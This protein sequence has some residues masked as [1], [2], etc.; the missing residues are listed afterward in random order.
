MPMDRQATRFFERRDEGQERRDRRRCACK[1][2]G[3]CPR[4]VMP[5][6]DK[7]DRCRYRVTVGG[8]LRC[9]R[10]LSAGA[11][12]RLTPIYHQSR[13]SLASSLALPGGR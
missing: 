9:A 2:C 7:C 1:E 5:G 10:S 11:P 6:G 13:S 12:Y 3:G 4:P 8:E